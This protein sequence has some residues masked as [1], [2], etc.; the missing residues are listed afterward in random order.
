MIHGLE[1]FESMEEVSQIIIVT[2]PISKEQKSNESNWSVER[3][4]LQ[5]GITKAV[6]VEGGETRQESVKNGL[7][8]VT[9]KSVLVAEAVRPF[10]T[11]EFVRRI[12]AMPGDCCT[13]WIPAISTVLT[14]DGVSLD[15]EK[16]GQVQM[17]QKYTTALLKLAHDTEIVK[18][19]TD[20]AA[21]LFTV[22]GIKPVLVA[23]IEENIKI[24][25]P[26]DLVIAEAIYDARH[27]N[28]E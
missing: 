5:Y 19:T 27:Y 23:G 12:I 16:V 17:P 18:N 8:M 2:P 14:A 21:L 10:I 25:T 4:V 13:P 15:R 24:T 26:L 3:T 9:T 28:R 11:H 20:D 1:V 22:L 6:F 7:E